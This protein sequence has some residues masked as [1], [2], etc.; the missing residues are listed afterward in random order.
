MHLEFAG[1][2]LAGGEVTKTIRKGI[3]DVDIMAANLDIMVL[4]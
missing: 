4:G 1:A 3:V 2:Y